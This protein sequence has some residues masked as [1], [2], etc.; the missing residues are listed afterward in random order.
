M[1]KESF[2]V[3][4]ID[5]LEQCGIVGNGAIE[6]FISK[7]NIKTEK[8]ALK[9]LNVIRGKGLIEAGTN[10]SFL[11]IFFLHSI[12]RRPLIPNFRYLHIFVIYFQITLK[13]VHFQL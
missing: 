10:H 13:F 12:E 11:S 7:M 3:F 8:N 1:S 5:Y 4:G 9:L 2:W 6:T